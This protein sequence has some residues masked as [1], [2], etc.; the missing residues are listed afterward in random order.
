MVEIILVKYNDK[1]FFDDCIKSIAEHTESVPYALRAYD[2]FPRNHNLGWLWNNLIRQ[3][4]EKYICLLNTDTRVT[5]RWLD[6]IMEVFEKEKDVGAV[7]VS[8]THSGNPQE[9]GLSDK[10]YDIVDYCKQ[11]SG[12][13]LCG[14]CLVFPKWIWEQ[15]GGFPENFGFYGQEEG[16]LYKVTA[17]GYKQIWRKDVFIWH[18]GGGSAKLAEE[19]GEINIEEEKAEGR[20]NRDKVKKE[21]GL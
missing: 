15:V 6:K 21:L 4:E 8:T 13:N 12:G 9:G 7:S 5:K 2:N 19:R 16:F 14:F 3:S 1:V 20:K 18:Y 11:Y 17:A 10:E